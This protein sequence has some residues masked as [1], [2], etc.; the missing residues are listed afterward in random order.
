MVRSWNHC[1]VFLGKTL[2]YFYSA[3]LPLRLENCLGKP[4]EL[5]VV[6][7]NGITSHPGGFILVVSCNINMTG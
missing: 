6:T 7:Y 3:S 5:L 4:E 1:V 2:K